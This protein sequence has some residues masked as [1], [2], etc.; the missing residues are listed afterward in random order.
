MHSKT[1]ECIDNSTI[2][3]HGFNINKIQ[4]I[5]L[6][7]KS[8]NLFDTCFSGNDEQSHFTRGRNYFDKIP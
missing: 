6:I 1:I 4:S 7:I 5:P 3:S 2:S 8:T